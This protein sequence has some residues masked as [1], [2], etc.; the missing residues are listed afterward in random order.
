MNV[1]RLSA[2][3]LVVLSA[4]VAMAQK[5]IKGRV[6]DAKD[7]SGVPGAT[8][9]IP[10]STLGAKSDFDGNF[11]L[12]N[13]P[14]DANTVEVSSIGYDKQMV[15][16]A[17]GEMVIKMSSKTKT[18]NDLVVVGYGTQKKEGV[19]GSVAMV[20]AKALE[21]KP[22]GSFQNMLQGKA[23]GV[24]VTGVNG[25]PGQNA[26]IRVRGVGSLS[27]GTGPLY[28]VDGQPV[29]TEAYNSINPNDIESISVLK[30]PST[31]SIYGSRGSNG[32]V[33]ITTKKGKANKTELKYAFQ[34]GIKTKTKDNFK[35]MS[36]DQ[37]L[38]Y[39]K[40]LGYAN[41]YL[42]PYLDQNGY[43]TINDVPDAEYRGLVDQL[44]KQS[45]DWN[46]ELLRSANFTS[47]DVSLSGGTDKTRIFLSLQSWKEEGIGYGSDFD[48]KSGRLNVTHKFND[49]FEAGTNLMFANKKENLL[50]E[51]YNA[52]NPFFAM[53]AYNPYEPVYL[54]DGSYN[55]TSQ[56]FNVKEGVAN[57]PEKANT[58]N[59]LANLYGQVTFL[60]NFKFRTELG[61]EYTNYDREYFVKPNSILD[62]Y[63]GN[64]AKP[65]SKTDNGFNKFNYR[66]TN[67]LNY[68][69]TLGDKHNIGFLGGTE[70]T[71][72][73]QKSFSISSRG[74][75]NP[76]YNVESVAA[77]N[78]GFS[79]NKYMWTLFSMFARGEY[80]YANKYFVNA[81]IRRD[82]SSRFGA[83]NKYGNFYAAGASWV[84]SREDFLATAKN[85]NELRL[86]ASI[87]TSGNNEIGNYENLQ[88]YAFGRY[89]SL[90]ASYPFQPGNPLLTWEKSRMST[91]GMDYAF[92]DSRL[93]GT[94]AVFDKTT[95][96]LL[97]AKPL[98]LTTGFVS[99]PSNVGGLS[100]KGIEIAAAY[101]IIRTR[102]WNW[103]ISANFTTQK[104]K[105]TA[106]VSNEDI[107][108]DITR[109]SVGK[110]INTYY[111]VRYAG[112]DAQTG[113]AL[114]Y[115]KNGQ[116]T[117]EYKSGDAVYLDGKTPDPRYFGSVT[118][119]VSYKGITLG[120]DFYY[121]GGN[122]IYNY[123][124]RDLHSGLEAINQNQ[125][126][127]A[128]DYWKQPGDKS[129]YADPSQKVYSTDQWL[130]KGDFIR[131]RNV[132]LAYS[133]PASIMQK[134]HMKGANVYVQG[135]NLFYKAKHYKGDPEVGL[136]NS[137]QTGYNAPGMY[138]L[139]AYPQVSTVSFG[140]N[141]TL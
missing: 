62:Y 14:S 74:Y 128:L 114:Y 97:L 107:P 49:W 140:L 92:F 59:G 44:R 16:V 72:E 27:A 66:W 87:G 38:R 21:N 69:K 100:N 51:T 117:D 58:L 111:L 30:D 22:F 48:R 112:V 32:V 8:I 99:Q 102:D 85:I 93:S 134:V 109:W 52:Q 137:E 18:L 126:A 19:S 43:S 129:V 110:A 115:D 103:N 41:E 73:E 45:T 113:K 9:K 70:Y 139:Y 95:T 90:S 83:E 63:T 7:G 71:Q 118:T 121:Q 10:G 34:H 57:N 40:E 130:Q 82:G 68:N 81:S 13:A 23:A 37:K 60:K 131:L 136:G 76:D 86:F 122:Y 53:Y 56:G 54:P 98:S 50:R 125:A 67:V 61:T 79:T 4:N 3:S 26:Y 24:Q 64:P 108:Q 104:N 105:V 12:L 5:V 89:N 31:A 138:S 78:T 55:F 84:I 47:H 15:V 127:D 94:V 124:W 77:E 96:S 91:I 135:Q 39:E 106:L 133:M 116:V 120:V 2:L 101:D 119:S 42:Q 80:N 35:M 132:T 46:K 75:A 20:D 1:K 11:T 65:G 123:V 36:F 28:V 141:V 29:S 17:A 33:M 25:R 88:T 6:V